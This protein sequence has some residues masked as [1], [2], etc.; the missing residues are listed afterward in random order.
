VL[1]D[2]PELHLRGGHPLLRTLEVF[3]L[4]APTYRLW[5]V[6]R[7]DVRVRAEPFEALELDLAR[8]WAT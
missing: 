2:E 4:D 5:G 3:R 7:G 1:L 6:W 8:L